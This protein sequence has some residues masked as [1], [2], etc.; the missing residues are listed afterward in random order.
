MAP[1]RSDSIVLSVRTRLILTMLAL[2]TAVLVAA[3][4]TGYLLELATL[5]RSAAVQ[6]DREAD[7]FAGLAR[8]AV[9]PETGRPF[10]TTSALLRTAIQQRVLGAGD[11]VLGI[12]DRRIEWTAQAG[13]PLRLEDHAEL[14]AAVLTHVNDETTTQGRLRTPE[15]DFLY[16]VMPVRSPT[17][18]AS[19]ALVRAIDLRV[20][21]RTLE[22]TYTL[23]AIAAVTVA[24]A[25]GLIAWAVMGRLLAPIA[26][27]REAAESIGEDE[28]ARRIPVRG[29]DDLSALTAT[30]N[31]MLDRIQN[32][33][34]GQRQL[35]DDVG[36]ELRTPLTIL[37]GHLELLDVNN[38]D[39]VW[40]TRQLAL[41]EIDRLNRLTDDLIL[42]ASSE[43]ADFVMPVPTEIAELT[44]ETFELV[45]KLAPRPWS[46]DGLA[47]ISANLDPQRIRQAWLQ[48]A[49]NAVKYS[50][51]GSAIAIGSE[52]RGAEVWL[53]VRDHGPGIA[54]ADRQRILQ[55]N[56]RGE[57]ALASGRQGR[58]L[59]LAI[60]TKI[61]EAN[62]GRLAITAA[63]GGGSI[64]AIVLP[65]PSQPEEVKP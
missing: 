60:V 18:A 2:M 15:H 45:R 14:V 11:G 61:V 17:G 52:Q 36:H 34:E 23:Y 47:E 4:M 55:R 16:L 29:R 25:A 33:V 49:D 43:R 31:G 59:G 7:E 35:A 65:V 30:I 3:G 44:D 62:G 19:G 22:A 20:A 58:G 57:L 6:L 12:V 39:Q 32:L 27:L 21:Q 24:L 8:N 50:P 41:E 56:V 1:I 26:R 63:P 10:E 37:R 5:E 54:E 48:L 9:D 38:P 51:A 42:L 13:V 64:F 28:L 53:W 40:A 46:L